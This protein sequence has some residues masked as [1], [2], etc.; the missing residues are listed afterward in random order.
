FKEKLREQSIAI[1]FSTI[2]LTQHANYSN[3]KVVQV[4]PINLS[5]QFDKIQSVI[6]K[7]LEEEK[8]QKSCVD[9]HTFFEQDLF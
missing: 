6:S 2:P 3:L 4:S 5:S 8:N 7:E 9:F 1:V